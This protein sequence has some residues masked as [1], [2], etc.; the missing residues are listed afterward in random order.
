MSVAGGDYVPVG[1]SGSV[2][3]DLQDFLQS[4]WVRFGILLS[5][6]LIIVIGYVSSPQEVHGL[7]DFF[8]VLFNSLAVG[9]EVVGSTMANLLGLSH[10]GANQLM[11][12]MV[13]CVL[14]TLFIFSVVKPLMNYEIWFKLLIL[15]VLIGILAIVVITLAK[16]IATSLG[17]QLP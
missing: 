16:F 15:L 4:K 13:R 3:D 10:P 9:T 14:S 12:W 8:F 6:I 17:V 7:D 2:L 11:I 1:G 5:I